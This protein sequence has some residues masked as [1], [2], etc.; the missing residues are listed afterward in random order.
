M[1]CGFVKPVESVVDEAPGEMREIIIGK[2]VAASSKADLWAQLCTYARA[3][4]RTGKAQGWAWYRYKEIAGEKPPRN[5]KFD[6]T[7][8]V[9]VSSAVVGKI[10]SLRIAWANRRVA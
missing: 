3:N 5:W 8:D 6:S 7:P 2:R 9:P 10:K 4:I 1:S